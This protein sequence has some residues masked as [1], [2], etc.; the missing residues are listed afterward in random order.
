MCGVASLP[1]AVGVYLP[2]SSSSPILV[3]GAVRWLVDR[4]IR[5]QNRGMT[6]EEL[7]AEG[8]KSA[9]VLMASGYI[10]GGAI[11]GIVIAF[12]AGVLSDLQASID[13]WSTAHNPFYVGPHAD[14]LSLLPFAALV[15]LL[16]LSGRSRRAS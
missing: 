14:V 8:D 10:A 16:H 1:F 9:G 6:E 5:R 2:L 15:V 11:A 13:V 7:T 12:V 3:G 4:G